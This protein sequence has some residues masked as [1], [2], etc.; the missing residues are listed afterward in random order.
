MGRGG[1][2]GGGGGGGGGSGRGGKGGKG[3]KP[4]FTRVIPKFLQQYETML[5]GPKPGRGG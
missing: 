3:P 4:Q 2:C 1:K 5:N